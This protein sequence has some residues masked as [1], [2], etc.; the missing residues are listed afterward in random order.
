MTEDYRTKDLSAIRYTARLWVEV[1]PNEPRNE[2]W[3]LVH[4]NTSTMAYRDRFLPCIRRHQVKSDSCPSHGPPSRPS[5]SVVTDGTDR[6]THDT[7]AA[8]AARASTTIRMHRSRPAIASGTTGRLTVRRKARR[9]AA[10]WATDRSSETSM[11]GTA[12]GTWTAPI[13]QYY[14]S[15]ADGQ[16]SDAANWLTDWMTDRQTDKA[17]RDGRRQC[18]RRHHSSKPGKHHLVVVADTDLAIARRAGH[19]E[20]FTSFFFVNSHLVMHLSICRAG[21]SSNDD[22]PRPVVDGTPCTPTRSVARRPGRGHVDIDDP[23]RWAVRCRY[24]VHRRDMN[25]THAN[26]PYMYWRLR[27]PMTYERGT[28]S[29]CIW[30]TKSGR[31]H[32]WYWWRPEARCDWKYNVNPASKNDFRIHFVVPIWLHRLDAGKPRLYSVVKLWWS[33]M[34]NIVLV[35]D[36]PGFWF[37]SWTET[38]ASVSCHFLRHNFQNVWKCISSGTDRG[39][40]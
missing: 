35:R 32:A 8:S 34:Y 10:R 27:S 25:L 28:V 21:I 40:S 9:Q 1:R 39:R 14:Q 5:P 15:P 2:T 7:G 36:E 11:T 13:D 24:I 22:R 16:E 6:P 31:R 23:N 3:D 30:R 17:L 4:S 12:C 29:W 37:G 38:M 18:R 26:N 19:A 20:P 33:R